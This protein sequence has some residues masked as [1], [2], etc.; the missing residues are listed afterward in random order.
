VRSDAEYKPIN[1]KLLYDYSGNENTK[2]KPVGY[3]EDGNRRY[4]STSPSPFQEQQLH[5]PTPSSFNQMSFNPQ[6]YETQP[7][8]TSTPS[9]KGSLQQSVM[10]S[11]EVPPPYQPSPDYF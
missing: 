1:S 8:T 11:S 3:V 9:Q 7:Y 10:Y 4:L 2:T 5:A 6:H